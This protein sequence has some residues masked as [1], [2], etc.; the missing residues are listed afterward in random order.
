MADKDLNT[1]K[2]VDSLQNIAGLKPTRRREQ[3]KRRQNFQEKKKQQSEQELN[4]SVDEQDFNGEL[5]EN[6]NDRN[7]IDY[8]A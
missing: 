2:P 8:H 7:T 6:E 4:E 5:T 3:R 1:I